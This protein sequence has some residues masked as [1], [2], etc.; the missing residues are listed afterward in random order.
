MLR[1][2]RTHRPNPDLD[3]CCR[4][5]YDRYLKLLAVL[6]PVWSEMAWKAP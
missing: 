1:F 4:T 2:A 5:K 3:D 6:Q